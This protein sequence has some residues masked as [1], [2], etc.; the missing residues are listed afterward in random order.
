ASRDRFLSPSPP[1]DSDS[2]GSTFERSLSSLPDLA[3]SLSFSF[4]FSFFESSFGELSFVPSPE[5]PGHQ[6]PLPPMPEPPPWN[7]THQAIRPHAT[8]PSVRMN[9]AIRGGIDC[10]K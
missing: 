5:P 1:T 4:S 8:A 7:R 10:A 2:P 3:F 9:H 6:P